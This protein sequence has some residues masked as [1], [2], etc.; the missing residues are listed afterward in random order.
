MYIFMFPCSG[1]RETWCAEFAYTGSKE[2][3]AK[4]SEMLQVNCETILAFGHG[5]SVS[6]QTMANSADQ[7]TFPQRARSS[8]HHS[9]T[10]SHQLKCP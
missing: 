3:I 4:I 5:G 10:K 9:K 6:T 2:L 1:I 7:N 8:I